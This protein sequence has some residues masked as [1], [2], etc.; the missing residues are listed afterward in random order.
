MTF[1]VYFLSSIWYPIILLWY[2]LGQK[3]EI[4]NAGLS[5]VLCNHSIVL[6]PSL[7]SL[8][9][10]IVQTCTKIIQRIN[11]LHEVHNNIMCTNILKGFHDLAVNQQMWEELITFS[12]KTT[13]FTLTDWMVFNANF[14]SISAT[15]WH[16]QISYN[17]LDPFLHNHV[18][19]CIRYM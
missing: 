1:I 19:Q 12:Q 7:F 9:A 11:T 3:Y 8:I 18:Y 6:S 15:T 16:E 14:S 10:T 17:Y 2:L 4:L 5:I 13:L